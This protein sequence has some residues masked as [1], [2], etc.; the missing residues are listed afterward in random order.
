MDI[1]GEYNI[2]SENACSSCLSLI[3][4]AM[5]KLKS[6]GEYEKNKDVRILIGRKKEILKKRDKLFLALIDF[7]ES[8][9]A[10]D[11]V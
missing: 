3:G 6:L 4:L 1:S 8:I 10:F 11:P 5:E 9:N 7:L 2:D